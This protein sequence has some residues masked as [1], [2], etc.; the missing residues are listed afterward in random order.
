MLRLQKPDPNPS[1]KNTD[2][3]DKSMASDF[4][5]R[6]GPDLGKKKHKPETDPNQYQDPDPPAIERK[7]P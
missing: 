7:L 5:G 1:F 6:L 2:P 3:D 4:R